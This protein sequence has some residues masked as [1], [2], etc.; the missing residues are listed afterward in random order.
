VGCRWRA[1]RPHGRWRKRGGVR[2]VSIFLSG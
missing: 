1:E 2:R